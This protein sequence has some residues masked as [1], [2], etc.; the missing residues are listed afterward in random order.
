[1]ACVLIPVVAA[2]AVAVVLVLRLWIVCR[3]QDVTPR[4]SLSLLVVAGSGG[5]TTEILRLLGSLSSA[6]SPRH[7]VIADTDKMSADKINSFELDRADRDPSTMFLQ[8]YSA[9]VNKAVREHS[10]VMDSRYYIHRIPRS[11]EVQQSWLSTVLTTLHS[12]WLSF[13]LI[14][15]VKPDLA[16]D[17]LL[18]PALQSGC[19]GWTHVKDRCCVMDQE[20]AFLS[21]SLPFFLE[22]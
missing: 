14:H 15:Q 22:Y 16:A 6:Y 1:M 2:G 4:E 19:R 17:D 3:S 7:Y 13:P 11:R 18:C 20:H 12:M 9:P 21:V 5:H 10:A 8:I